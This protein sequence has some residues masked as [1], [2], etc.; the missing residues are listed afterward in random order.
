M[1]ICR[2][3]DDFFNEAESCHIQSYCKR[4]EAIPILVAMVRLDKG[5]DV[6]KTDL[7]LLPMLFQ[8]A[9]QAPRAAPNAMLI[10]LL[11]A[12]SDLGS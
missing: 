12:R 4:N 3:R 1:V 5:N 8:S 7:S 11:A 9:K 2:D 6:D 10:G